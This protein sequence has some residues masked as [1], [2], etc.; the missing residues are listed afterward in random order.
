MS[1]AAGNAKNLAIIAAKDAMSNWRY[2]SYPMDGL[3]RWR[4]LW[5]RRAKREA[6][7]AELLELPICGREDTSD[8][9]RPH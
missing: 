3:P 7:L 2:R 8:E 5:G 6:P 9:N 1:R 4:I